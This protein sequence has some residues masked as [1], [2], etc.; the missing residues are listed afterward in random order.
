ME[1]RLVHLSD[2]EA[3]L[4]SFPIS[5]SQIAGF[6]SCPAKFEHDVLGTGPRLPSTPPAVIGSAV[7][8]STAVFDSSR[9]DKNKARWLSAD[10]T[11]EVLL[12]Y[13][14]D[15][16]EEVD[17]T[18]SNIE[19]AATIALGVHTRYCHEV[20]P[21]H[22]YQHVEE[23]MGK[24]P[25]Q[26]EELGIEIVL[27][28]TLDRTFIKDAKYG[29]ADLKTGAVA[30]SQHTGKHKA[31][32]GAYELLAEQ[33]LGII[34]EQHGELIQLQTSSNYKVAVQQVENARLALLGDDYNTGM[35]THIARALK[36]GDFWGNP[37]SWLCSQKY[38]GAWDNCI[39]R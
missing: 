10:D 8:K 15:P 32:L 7:H 4:E 16:G 29:I 30:C 6:F 19:K 9:L 22:T 2:R 37:S 23:T 25:I 18:G 5:A 17:W 21:T 31:Q 11:A 20:A 36:S 26:W 28:G 27:S 35:L 13:I 38:C 3:S 12:E 14:K 39:Y 34:I 1:T 24:L 33:E